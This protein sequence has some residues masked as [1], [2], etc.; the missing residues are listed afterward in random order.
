[1]K[2]EMIDLFFVALLA[3]GGFLLYF[4]TLFMHE[5]KRR[6][7]RAMPFPEEWKRIIEKN[8]RLFEKLPIELRQELCGHINVFL[9]EKSFEGCGGLKITDE[10]KLTIAAS[11]CI[12]L[13]NRKTKYFSR[14]SAILVYPRPYV[15]GDYSRV[16][17][18][19]IRDEAVVRLGESWMQGA[20][21]LAWDHVLADARGEGRGG[22]VVIHEF[23][24]QLDQESGGSADGAPVFDRDIVSTEWAAVF[25]KEYEKLCWEA[26]HG[27]RDVIDEY[28]AVNPAEFFAVATESFF[29]KP[30]EMKKRHPELYDEMRKYY[31]LAPSDW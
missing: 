19:Y 31:K 1:M 6:R 14:L 12:L 28:G 4:L 2:I 9:H 7:L 30:R 15:A 24:H 11:A 17:S 22:N 13:L 3:A 29:E 16:G 21:V 26:S 20:V 27:V 5:R 10:I 8:V 23:A 25:S 18:Q